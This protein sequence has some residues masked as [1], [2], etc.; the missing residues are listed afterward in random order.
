MYLPNKDIDQSHD[1]IL[2]TTIDDLIE[3]WK[4]GST[5]LVDTKTYL[6]LVF[7]NPCTN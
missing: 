6:S 2:C 5:L 1:E 3:K 4:L 7:E